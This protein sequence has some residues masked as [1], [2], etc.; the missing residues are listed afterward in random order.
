MSE[1]YQLEAAYARTLL[2][3]SRKWRQFADRAMSDMGVSAAGGWALVQVGRLGD[4]VRQSDLAAHLDITGPSLVRVV[5]QLVDAGLVERR[6]DPV[7]ARVSRVGFTESGRALATRIESAF[8]ELRREILADVTDTD[9]ATALRV[10]EHL[11]AC[12]AQPRRP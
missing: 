3:L 10:A 2:P 8:G 6:R 11:E 5:D 9:L 1:R 12:F 4:D 7:D